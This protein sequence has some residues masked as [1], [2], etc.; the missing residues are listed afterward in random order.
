[1][2]C[3]YHYNS[4]PSQFAE[5][6]PDAYLDMR[7]L[8]P[9]IYAISLRELRFIIGLVSI[10]LQWQL[11]SIVNISLFSCRYLWQKRQLQVRNYHSE[12]CNCFNFFLLTSINHSFNPLFVKNFKWVLSTNLIRW[13]VTCTIIIADHCRNAKLFTILD[14]TNKLI[15]TEQN[16]KR[17]IHIVLKW[18]M[19]IKWPLQMPD[20]IYNMYISFGNDIIK[21]YYHTAVVQTIP[22]LIRDTITELD[23][24]E[25]Q[26]DTFLALCLDLFL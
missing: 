18:A 24:T 1:M 3:A 19:L 12:V 4:N 22:L 8:P 10:Y 20:C 13:R 17:S 25:L 9:L 14:L 26:E 15:I 5:Q 23:D 2:W 21:P 6:W 11:N 16:V 7:K